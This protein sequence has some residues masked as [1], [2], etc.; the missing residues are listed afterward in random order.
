ML[1]RRIK[2][3][4]KEQDWFA[5]GIDFVIVVVGVFI[6]IQVANWNESVNDRSRAE[7]YRD[8]LSQEMTINRG[9]LDSRL[10]SFA[11]QIEYGLF[12]MDATSAPID[13]DQAWEVIR[14]FFQSSH[15]FTIS[16]QHGTYDEIMSSG[17]LALL[18]D[19]D[20]VNALAE[21][22]TFAGYDTISVIPDFRENVRRLV[23]F[24]LQR[25]LQSEC[26]SVS[27][28]DNHFLIDCPPPQ[29]AEGLIQLATVLQTDKALKLDLQYMLS[30]VGVS[31]AIAENRVSKAELVLS[32]LGKAT[33]P[34]EE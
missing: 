17:D 11:S 23:P 26:Y 27:D 5:V 6:G 2:K 1:F 32:I 20:L 34:D 3:H 12:A 4:V 21:F 15:A 25:Y 7:N 22:Y 29:S 19:Q 30:Y 13:R 24:E 10:G 16:L 28:S 8:R 14:A 31:S 9:R 18:N 33:E